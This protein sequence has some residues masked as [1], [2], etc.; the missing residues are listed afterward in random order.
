MDS[1][2]RWNDSEVVH[3]DASAR[4]LPAWVPAFDGM[5]ASP[6]RPLAFADMTASL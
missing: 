4:A 3:R 2:F 6:D 1:S 5:T